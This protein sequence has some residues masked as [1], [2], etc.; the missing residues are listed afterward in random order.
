LASKLQL[1]SAYLYNFLLFAHWPQEEQ[2]FGQTGMTICVLGDDALA[3]TFAPVVDKA[4]KDSKYLLKVKKVR[5]PLQAADLEGCALLFIAEQASGPLA[6]ILSQVNG[7]PILTVSDLPDFAAKGGM[8]ALVEQ[9][10]K[11]RWRI[12]LGVAN[13]AGLRFDAQLLRNA[14]SVINVGQEGQ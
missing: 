14:E 11:L 5:L 2:A 13:Q 9:N 10:G 6:K 1:E 12:N 8:L 4:I 3:E 7:L